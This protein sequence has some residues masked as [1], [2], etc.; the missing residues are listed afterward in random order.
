MVELPNLCLLL[1]L[2]GQVPALTATPEGLRVRQYP[3]SLSVMR[4]ET[5]SLSC[6]FK[7]ESLKYGVQWFKIK[8]EK[9]IILKSPRHIVVEKNKTSSLMITEVALE[10][11]GWYYCVV[12]VLQKD[13]EWGNGTELVVLAP[14]SPPKMYLRI[15][16]D[17]QT[18]QWA[19]LCLTG[20]FHPNKLNLVWTYQST[21]ADINH[22]SVTNCTLPALNSHGNLSE[23][24]VDGALLSSDWL[25]NSMP[26]HQSKCFQ[27]MDNHSR[28]MFLFSV[29]ILPLKQSLDT[30]ITFTCEV[31]D[32]P[33]ITTALTSS[34]T[35]DASPNELIAHLN[36]LKMCFLSAMTVVFLLEVEHFCK[37]G[38]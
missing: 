37:Q 6:H 34:F 19:L 35:W 26:V 33:A 29:F 36:I 14:P 16:E 25:V 30:G 18:G 23:Q 17:P 20:G 31:R 5:A 38:K 2:V 1:L 28:E 21:A 7:V 15:P 13:P 3:P 12:N 22:L 11:S 32:H 4:G 8:P 24:P 10:D 27:V 9:Q